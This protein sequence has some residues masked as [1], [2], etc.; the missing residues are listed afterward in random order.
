M[1]CTDDQVDEQCEYM[2]D[3]DEQCPQH[4]AHAAALGI[5]IDPDNDEDPQNEQSKGKNHPGKD[6]ENSIGKDFVVK[7]FGSTERME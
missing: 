6:M 1:V 5:P 3:E 7:P 2:T 4:T